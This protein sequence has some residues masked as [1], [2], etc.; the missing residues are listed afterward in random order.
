MPSSRKRAMTAE[1]LAICI[2][3]ISASCMRAPPEAA[4]QI[5]GQRF[6][7]ATLAARTKRSPTMEPMEPPMKENSKAQVTTGRPRSRPLM[8]TRASFSPVSFCAALRRS[9]Y[10]LLSRNFRRSTGS[11]SA[12]I[13][14]RPSASRKKFRRVRALMRMWW[15]HLGQTSRVF[16]SSGR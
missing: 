15:S 9:L 7:R 11:S 3:E 10:F 4:K 5:S 6:S 13:S 2:R 12:P 1:V 8:A 16:S 14:S